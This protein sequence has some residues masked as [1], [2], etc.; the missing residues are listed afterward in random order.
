[1]P[2][3]LQASVLL[4]AMIVASSMAELVSDIPSAVS[5]IPYEIAYQKNRQFTN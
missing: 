5:V 1:M 3:P 4:A 2:A